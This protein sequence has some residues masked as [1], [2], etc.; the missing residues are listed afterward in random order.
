MVGPKRSLSDMFSDVMELAEE[1]TVCKSTEELLCAFEN[2]NNTIHSGNSNTTKTTKIIGSMD[3]I[4]LFPNIEVER[5][6]EIVV[7]EVM[8]NKVKFQDLDK[9]EIT[10]Y[11][12]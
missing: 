10:R 8:E 5:A 9:K 4:S 7:S 3:A 1:D 2:Y 6:V 11:I 12:F